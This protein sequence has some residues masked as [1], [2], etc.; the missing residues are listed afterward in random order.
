[1]TGAITLL[2]VALVAGCASVSDPSAGNGLPGGPAATVG[3][4]A[5]RVVASVNVW[6]DVARQIGGDRVS[7]TSI[8]SDP[9]VDPHEYE[10]S[11]GAAAALADAALVILNGLGYDEFASK[12]LAASPRPDRVVLTAA[13]V[14]RP[15]SDNPHLWYYP[16][17]VL[18]TARAIEAR[19]AGID[20]AGA[21]AYVA[22]LRAFQ[23]AYV[24]V[25]TVIAKIN[26]GY[27]GLAVAYTERVPGYLAQAAGLRLGVP[28]SFAR[29]IEDG[30]DPSPRDEVAFRDALAKH[31]VAALLYNTQAASPATAQLR[32]LAQRDGVPVVEVT[33]T[34]PPS[35]SDIQS[36]QAAQATALLTAL[37][38][39]V[40]HHGGCPCDA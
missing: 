30:V 17:Y 4:G 36:W 33:E 32:Q 29:A 28:E 37:G 8:I 12:L 22:N 10:T 24:S 3:H 20:P 13:D 2:G 18:A 15:T 14:A 5:I 26:A 40:S 19:L 21:A 9:N 7:V 39:P 25:S 34:L 23:S 6:G 35:F 38:G 1:L 16:S 31:T 11:V 27:A